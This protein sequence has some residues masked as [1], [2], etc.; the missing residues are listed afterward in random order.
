MTIEVAQVLTGG[1]GIRTLDPLK[2]SLSS[3]GVGGGLKQKLLASSLQGLNWLLSIIFSLVS[4]K[5]RI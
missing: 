3:Y 5:S 2:L 4:E 1:A